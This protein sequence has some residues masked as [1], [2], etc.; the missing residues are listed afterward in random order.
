MSSILSVKNLN[1]SFG[2]KKLLSKVNLEIQPGELI[3]LAGPNGCGKTS[4]MELMIGLQKNDCINRD[5]KSTDYGYL[6]QM[7]KIF[8][9][10]SLTL[11]DICQHPFPFYSEDLFN[12]H[13]SFASGGEKMKSLIARALEQSEKIVF[14]DEP[15][16]HLDAKSSHQLATYIQARV[17]AGLTVVYIGH[18]DLDINQRL[19]EVS[20][21]SC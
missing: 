4:L 5:F 3:K 19:I 17:K 6:P 15:F 9:K 18:E 2:T 13:W 16:N 14:L 12:R 11:G 10:I 8:P 7:S 21:W 20:Q 1:L